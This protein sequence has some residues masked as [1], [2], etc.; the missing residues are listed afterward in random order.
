MSICLSVVFF[1][2]FSANRNVCEYGMFSIIRV[3]TEKWSIHCTKP[4]YCTL[5]TTVHAWYYTANA[6]IHVKSFLCVS[7]FLWNTVIIMNR[8][9]RKCATVVVSWNDEF[10]HTELN[11]S[12]L[13]ILI[14]WYLCNNNMRLVCVCVYFKLW[15]YFYLFIFSRL[16]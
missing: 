9:D 1:F 4:V 10:L 2:V 15:R 12:T 3:H 5:H 8:I 7:Y 11:P 6:H 14:L 13:Y 16:M